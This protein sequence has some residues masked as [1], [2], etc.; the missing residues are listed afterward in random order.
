MMDKLLRG[1]LVLVVLLCP[2]AVMP[3]AFAEIITVTG[4]DSYTMGDGL[5]ESIETAKDIA[6]KKAMLNA[7]QQAGVYVESLSAV[8]A[9]ALK[10]DEIRAF[11]SRLLKEKGTPKF[12]QEVL[13]GNIIRYHCEVTVQV[14]TA[15]ITTQM[16][17]DRREEIQQ[18]MDWENVLQGLIQKREELKAKI[19]I[20]TSPQQK[21]EISQ[22][23]QKNA[24]ALQADK[25]M[26]A[27]AAFYFNKKYDY[28]IEAFSHAIECYPQCA[29]HYSNRATA[30]SKLNEMHKAL[31]DY[32][33]AIELEPEKA[34]LYNN[35]G[36]LYAD[37]KAYVQALM[38]YD[39]AIALDPSVAAYY[40]N[41]GVAY[42]DSRNWQQAIVDYEKAISLNPHYVHA[43]VNLGNVYAKMR[44]YQMAIVCY[45][46]AIAIDPRDLIANSNRGRAY[47]RLGDDVKTAEAYS[48]AIDINPKD[49]GLYHMRAVAY[50]NLKKYQKALMDYNMAIDL[51][52]RN[53]DAYTN[54]GVTYYFLAHYKKALADF[55]K[56][57]ALNPG[58]VRAREYRRVVS[59]IVFAKTDPEVI[60]E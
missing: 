29:Y 14:D 20:A 44:N 21:Q 45:D 4:R 42:E 30:Y 16:I 43:H 47:S 34:G 23:A 57:V 2:F 53:A 22:Q 49:A 12:T 10:Q 28:A 36:Q 26:K 17:A 48:K 60:T 41:R 56:A 39:K 27:G 58:D 13:A 55:D 40:Y 52:P 54:R 32:S 7:S 6:K 8:Q 35:R 59:D 51:N 50:T 25:W 5:N 38:D 37:M 19:A 46:K 33:K 24:M 18:I 1:T 9:S 11:A 15:D 3:T 31:A